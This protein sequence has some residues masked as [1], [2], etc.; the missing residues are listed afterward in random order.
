MKWAAGLAILVVVAGLGTAANAA[1]TTYEAENAQLTGGARAETE[2][3]GYT[4]SGYAG[5]FVDANR[6]NAAA[7]FTVTANRAG[8]H[9]LTIRYA[10]GTGSARTMSLIVNGTTRQVAL[11]ATAT[12]QTWGTVTQPVS[13]NLGGNSVA[14]KFGAND[15]GNL[16]LDHIAV[17]PIDAPADGTLE[18][19]TAT[20][21]GG[22][23]AEAEHPGY[24]GAGY[25][26]G[27]T[28]PTAATRPQ[29][30]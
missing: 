25:V 17:T 15:N 26:G 12:W 3:T 22:A 19:E 13:L 6:G 29:A 21:S 14:V 24:T 30:L 1:A 27:F 28:D 4:G 8:S 2:H 5:G 20:L 11:P 23:V 10:N 16:N 9:T 18:A 7:T